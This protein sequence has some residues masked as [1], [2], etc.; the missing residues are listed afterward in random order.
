MKYM[1]YVKLISFYVTC[2]RSWDTHE[3][4]DILYEV[5]MINVDI[6]VGLVLYIK[7]KMLSFLI[8]HKNHIRRLIYI[9]IILKIGAG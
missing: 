7:V 4:W 8:K 1:Y 9:K 6:Y 5:Y 2:M 3:I